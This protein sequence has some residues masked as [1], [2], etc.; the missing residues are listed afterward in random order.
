M[1]S[2]TVQL[3]PEELKLARDVFDELDADGNGTL[4]YED[5]MKVME[6]MGVKVSEE[7]AKVISEADCTKSYILQVLLEQV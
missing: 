5:I 7:E 2:E 6:R 4:E 1:A 3:T